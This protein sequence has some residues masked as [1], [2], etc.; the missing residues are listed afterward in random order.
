VIIDRGA[1]PPGIRFATPPD[2][3]VNA[4]LKH[5]PAPLVDFGRLSPVYQLTRGYSSLSESS[6]GRNLQIDFSGTKVQQEAL[7]MRL[8]KSGLFS[9][10]SFGPSGDF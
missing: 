7:A 5:Q 8:R 4:I 3:Q 9:K 1:L 10:V 2:Q 6:V